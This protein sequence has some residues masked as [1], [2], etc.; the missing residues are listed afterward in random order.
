MTKLYRCSF[1]L[2]KRCYEIREAHLVSGQGAFWKLGKCY[3]VRRGSR[4]DEVQELST[5]K[6]VSQR[7]GE[8]RCGRHS[9]ELI[10]RVGE[11]LAV[12]DEKQS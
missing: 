4:N 5:F 10:R 12:K 7:T 1:S 11:G 6:S 8:L 2:S 3:Q 9:V